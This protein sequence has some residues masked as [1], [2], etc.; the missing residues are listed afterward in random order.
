MSHSD[1]GRPTDEELEELYAGDSSVRDLALE[2]DVPWHTARKWL[3]EAGVEVEG[4]ESEQYRMLKSEGENGSELDDPER[5]RGLYV[6]QGMTQAE[7]GDEHGVSQTTVSYYLDKHDI[8]TGA[9]DV[10]DELDNPHYMRR[11]YVVDGFTAPDIAAKHGVSTGT[12]LRRLEAHG[13][14]RDPPGGGSRKDERLTDRDWLAE[15]LHEE[16]LSESAV[17]AEADCTESTVRHW[18]RKLL[19]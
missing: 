6:E 16:G 17:A 13:I 5:L 7:I 2:H 8:E 1:T 4:T 11:L 19:V 9:S 15:K 12:V 10:P 14:E 3:D 18:R